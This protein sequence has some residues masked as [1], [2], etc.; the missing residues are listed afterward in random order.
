MGFRIFAGEEMGFEEQV[1]AFRAARL[2][3]GPYGSGLVNAAF[4]A[5][6]AAFCELRSL[7]NPHN[8]PNWDNY[9][10]GLAAMMGFSYG[11]SVAENAPGA[12]A[13]ECDIPDVMEL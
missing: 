5:P 7:N 6:Q 4:A 11:I 10:L 13:W 12:D 2:I 3:V 8:S 9:Y 1:Y